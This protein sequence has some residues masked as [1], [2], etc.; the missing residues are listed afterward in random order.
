MELCLVRHGI[1]VERGSAGYT[2]DASRPL[3]DEGRERMGQVAAGLARLWTPELVVSSP[4]VRARET[5]EILQAAWGNPRMRFSEALAT[6]DHDE[7][8]ED[9]A[10]MDGERVAVV[11]HEPWI[12]GLLSL[13]LS[14]DTS[15][16]RSPFKKG[17][18]ALVRFAEGAA[19]P[20]AGEL[21]WFLPPRYSRDEA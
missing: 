17:G 13:V 5:A 19:G 8:F 4:L 10:D 7:L 20:G 14:G 9:M 11:G 2:N 6:G 3:T 21:A 1:A 16:V 15:L 18:A 12:S